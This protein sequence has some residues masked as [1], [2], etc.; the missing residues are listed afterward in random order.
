[1]IPVRKLEPRL[2]E[3]E[4]FDVIKTSLDHTLAVPPLVAPSEK[5]GRDPVFQQ[6][7][8]TPALLWC[9]QDASHTLHAVTKQ[10]VALAFK[11]AHTDL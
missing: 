9:M 5:K 3:A 7:G 1:M 10:L 6:V 4:Q 11:V 2:T 8:S